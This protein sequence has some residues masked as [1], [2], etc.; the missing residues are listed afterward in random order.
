[1]ILVLVLGRELLRELGVSAAGE[2]GVT[3][4]SSLEEAP[5]ESVLRGAGEPLGPVFAAVN[6]GEAASPLGEW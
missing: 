1:M 6:A 4:V 2:V 3:L 5:S